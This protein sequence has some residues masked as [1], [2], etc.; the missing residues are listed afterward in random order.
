M[1]YP[2]WIKDHDTGKYEVIPY[3]LFETFEDGTKGFIKFDTFMRAFIPETT[4]FYEK[5]KRYFKEVEV[6]S[7]ET[8]LIFTGKRRWVSRK[9]HTLGNMTL[10]LVNGSMLCL[11]AYHAVHEHAIVP[12]LLASVSLSSM[13]TI[14]W[15][16]QRQL[17]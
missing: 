8:R 7:F 3:H 4:N 12:W 17:G 15:L 10:I 1:K 13:L 2:V 9:L 5:H 11:N 16:E 14:I 6:D